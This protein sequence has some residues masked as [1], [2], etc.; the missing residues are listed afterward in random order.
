MMGFFL[1]RYSEALKR[2]KGWSL[3]IPVLILAYL[4]YAAVHDVR[5]TVSQDFAGYSGMLPVAASN[6]PIGMFTLDELVSHPELFFL[7]TFAL[8]QLRNKLGFLESPG[9]QADDIALRRL[10][11]R[12][13]S[14]SQDGETGLALCYIGKN[15]MLGRVLVSFYSDRL[16]KKVNEGARR[17]TQGAVKP[18][19]LSSA[20]EL[21]VSRERLLWSE[22]RLL[23]SVSIFLFSSIVMLVVIGIR[24]MAD[25]SFK[26]DRQVARYLESPVLG[27]MPDVGLLAVNLLEEER[28]SDRLTSSGSIR[29]PGA[30]Q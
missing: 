19:D 17:I 21:N 6:S 7:D 9:A 24:E 29:S 12:A 20:G 28:G 11:S 25:P 18:L 13:M 16:L 27:V 5:Y 23:P 22:D 15:P 1:K 4:I 14:F 2:H 26:S 8:T 3:L 30:S 10:L